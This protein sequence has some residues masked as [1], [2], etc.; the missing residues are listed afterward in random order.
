MGIQSRQF[1]PEMKKTKTK[2]FARNSEGNFVE[3]YCLHHP[4]IHEIM[5]LEF[6]AR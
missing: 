5:R 6:S 4:K 3:F 1:A 2:N